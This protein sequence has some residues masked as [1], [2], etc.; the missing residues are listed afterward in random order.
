[1]KPV[2][3]HPEADE[4]MRAAAHWY[5]VCQSGL[6]T[7]FLR[8]VARTGTLIANHPEAWPI[9]SGTVRRCLVDCFPFGLLYRVETDKIFILAVMHQKREPGYWKNRQI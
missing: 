1:M 7:R 8:E 2:E 5:H 3:L 6:G 4:E 9:V